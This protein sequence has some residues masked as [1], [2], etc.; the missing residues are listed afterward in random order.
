MVMYRTVVLGPLPTIGW[1]PILFAMQ[2]TDSPPFN[3]WGQLVVFL[4]AVGMVVNW[5]WKF[6]RE[7]R[8]GIP[9]VASRVEGIL[10]RLERVSDTQTVS[11]AGLT[12]SVAALNSTITLLG[13]RL[14]NIP[15][16]LDLQK[17]AEENR[18]ALRNILAEVQA[19]ILEAVR[20]LKP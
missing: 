9:K 17:A 8:N 14:T 11:I 18:H 3:S 5:L 12:T 16:K 13:E 15:T 19:N 7:K 10:E 6:V 1:M 2:L 4:I 20:E